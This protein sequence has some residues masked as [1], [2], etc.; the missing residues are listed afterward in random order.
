MTE[1]IGPGGTQPL[2]TKP[3]I[4]TVHNH[5]RITA[6]LWGKQSHRRKYFH[7]NV[8]YRLKLPLQLKRLLSRRKHTYLLKGHVNTNTISY[9]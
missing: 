8:T 2:S 5:S 4:Q 1:S 9:S 3:H 7:T 6:V